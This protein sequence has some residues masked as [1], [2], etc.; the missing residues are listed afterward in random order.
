MPERVAI[1]RQ[2]VIISGA[3][4]DQ[5]YRAF[6]SSKEHSEITGAK[7]TCSARVGAEFSAWDGYI[8]GKNVELVQGE[9]IVQEWK[10]SEWPDGYSPS[11]LQLSL[12]KVDSGTELTLVQSNVPASQAKDYEKGWHDL[13]WNPMKNYFA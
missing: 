8:S 5:V 11:K 6:L 7:A 4:P 1:I 2:K 3:T 9:K 13:Y 10:T 12:K